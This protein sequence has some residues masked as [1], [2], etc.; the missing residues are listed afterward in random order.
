MLKRPAAFLRALLE[1]D[2]TTSRLWSSNGSSS[3]LS[4]RS[5]PGSP[6]RNITWPRHYGQAILARYAY[7]LSSLDFVICRGQRTM[8]TR[9]AYNLGPRSAKT[10]RSF[11]SR[12]GKRDRSS[13]PC[14]R[15]DRF[16]S[17]MEQFLHGRPGETALL[18]YAKIASHP[19]WGNVST[20][21]RGGRAVDLRKDRF[22]S[23][24]G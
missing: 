13:P 11:T 2:N 16:P 19:R 21:G 20:V 24:M 1:Q 7:N 9:Y 4:P 6:S 8:L 10:T 5:Q 15:D 17:A 22:P 18:T 3:G 12:H 14:S 23:A